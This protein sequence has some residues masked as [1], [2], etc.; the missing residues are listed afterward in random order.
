MEYYIYVIIFISI[1]LILYA[2]Y[3][4]NIESFGVNSDYSKKYIIDDCMINSNNTYDYCL[5]NAWVK[6]PKFLC[7]LCGD[8]PSNSLYKNNDLYGCPKNKSN[9]FNLS[10]NNTK[11]IKVNPILANIQTCNS[12]NNNSSSDMYLYIYSN[13]KYNILLNNTNIDNQTDVYLL[14]NIKYGDLITINCE[15]GGLCVSYIWNKQLFILNNNGFE[16]SA[17]IINYQSQFSSNITKQ[18]SENLKTNRLPW[19]KLWCNCNTL[20]FNIGD[21]QKINMLSNDLTVFLGINNNGTV[22]LN[23]IVVY[24]KSE[25]YSKLVTFVVQNVNENDVLNIDCNNNTSQGGIGIVYLWCGFIYTLSSQN[26][27]AN[28][29]SYTTTNCNDITYPS[30]IVGDN[31]YFMSQWISSNSNNFTFKTLIGNASYKYLPSVDKWITLTRNNLIGKWSLT[32][33]KS[34]IHMTISFSINIKSITY[35]RNIIHV[36]NQNIDCCTPGNRVPAIWVTD[37]S[38]SLYISNGTSLNG[39]DVFLTK[40]IPLNIPTNVKIIWNGNN[41]DVY[42]N[43][44]LNT[45]YIYNGIVTLANPDAMFYIGDPW[46]NQDGGVDI[47]NLEISNS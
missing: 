38:S 30:P 43:N 47:Q 35:W 25:I 29:I 9:L 12:F 7:G 1:L 18:W 21:T 45:S 24:N 8:N 4:K 33:I 28:V 6:N 31:I 15:L 42:F 10:W 13:N 32:N 19:M 23:N 17:N 41:V 36:S 44:I 22:Y 14:K 20:N 5:Q 11:S 34:T 46:Y 40:N 39:D 37:S 16:N 2:L 27:M 26:L 3:N